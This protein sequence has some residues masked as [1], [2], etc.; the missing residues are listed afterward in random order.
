MATAVLVVFGKSLTVSDKQHIKH[1]QPYDLILADPILHSELASLGRA[2]ADIGA[3]MLPGSIYEGNAFLQDLSRQNLPNGIPVTKSVIYK[4]FALWWIH[5][6]RLFLHF[7]LPYTQYKKILS[8]IAEYTQVTL[9]NP[10]YHDMFRCHSEAYEYEL[11]TFFSKK[12]RTRLYPTPGLLVQLALTGLSILVLMVR[13]TPL[14]VYTGDKFETGKDYDPRMRFVYEELRRR[15]QPFVEYIR[16]LESWKIILEHAVTR[17]RPVIYTEAVAYFAMLLSVLFGTNKKYFKEQPAAFLKQHTQEARFKLLVATQYVGVAGDSIWAVRLMHMI[18]RVIGIRASFITAA[19]ER[20]FYTVLA[21]KLGKIPTIGILHGVASR[22]YNVYDF[23]PG[24]DGERQLSLDFYGMWSEW[25]K[26]YY[27]KYSSVYTEQQLTVSGPMRPV[28]VRPAHNPVVSPEVSASQTKVL[29]VSEVVAVPS[30]IIPYIDAV[31]KESNCTLFIKFRAVNDTFEAWL[32]DNRP[33]ILEI[34]GVERSL[35]GSMYDAI[36][37][38]DVVVGTQSTGVI[39]STLQ[40]KPFV[41][42]YTEKWGD[43]YDMERMNVQHTFFAKDPE[44]LVRAIRES[45]HIPKMVLKEFQ[46]KFFGDPTKNG[47]EWAVNQLDA[48]LSRR[49]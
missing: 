9:L 16:S 48:C 44:I 43:Y 17:R 45:T 42:F 31:L 26:S 23:M 6:E 38:C 40:E 21:C 39:E 14:L 41:L 25:W 5:Y 30:E 12:K 20:N 2:C 32:K 49:K 15:K 22:N 34:L 7:A 24:F 37:Q 10:S 46:T 18:S 28:L 11:K 19:C 13:R 36:T 29:L 27:L 4:G 8:C 33:D 3:Y 1:S 35:K 47:S